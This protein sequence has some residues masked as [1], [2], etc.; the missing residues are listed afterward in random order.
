MQLSSKKVW[1]RGLVV[2]GLAVPIISHVFGQDPKQAV[3]KRIAI[4]ARDPAS[5]QAPLSLD[6]IQT[7]VVPSRFEG[8]VDSILVKMGQTT[9]DKAELAKLSSE[10]EEM[11]LERAQLGLKLAK[12]QKEATPGPVAEVQVEL[13]AFDVKMAEAALKNATIRAPISGIITRVHVSPGQFVRV[14]DPIVT[15]IDSTKFRVEV[16]VDN[17][18]VKAGQQIDLRV[19]D[20][21]TKATVEATSPLTEKFSGLR[22]LF[23]AAATAMVTIDNA[24][25]QFVAGQTVYCD[26]VPRQPVVEAPTSAISNTADGQRR[27]QVIRGGFVRDLKVQVLGQAGDDYLFV[28]GRFDAGD[29]L[30]ESSSIELFDGS[31]VLPRS[32]PA[33]VAKDKP[34]AGTPA[35]VAPGTTPKPNTPSNF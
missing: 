6:P 15:V 32:A 2:L 12:V 8:T 34:A 28:A 27:V 26:M 20:I 33:P 25:G 17:R 13:A 23:A 7:I 11:K 19:E 14:G 30:V 5:F 18:V 1:V 22:N 4:V 16:P 3:I 21:K 31:R 29:E 10:F 35:P 9:S 24:K